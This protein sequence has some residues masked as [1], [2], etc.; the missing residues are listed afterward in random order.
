VP[1]A[2]LFEADEAFHSG[3]LSEVKPCIEVDG[4]PIGNGRVGPVTRAIFD[5]F[6]AETGRVGAS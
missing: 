4:K 5:A 3:T 2:E 1:L 6:L